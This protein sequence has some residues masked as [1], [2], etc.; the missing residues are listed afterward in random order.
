MLS[1]KLSPV[2]TWIELVTLSTKEKTGFNTSVRFYQ[3][4]TGENLY[5][6]VSSIEIVAYDTISM[7]SSSNSLSMIDCLP[8]PSYFVTQNLFSFIH[9]KR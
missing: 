6:F 1:Y 3:A 8:F 4:G 5:E 9:W 7:V 2:L